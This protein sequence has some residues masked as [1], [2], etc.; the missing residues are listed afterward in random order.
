MNNN[1]R[2]STRVPVSIPFEVYDLT[3]RMGRYWS[4]NASQEGVFLKARAPDRLSGILDLR[5][6]AEGREHRLRGVVVHRESK[7]GVGVQ[8][9]YWRKADQASHK[10]YMEISGCRQR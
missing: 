7:R 4:S 8:L 3:R 6:Q 10:A 2:R 1:L 5:F 9:A